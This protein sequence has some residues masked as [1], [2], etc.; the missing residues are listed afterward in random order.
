MY[1]L[2]N[3][4]MIKV[5]IVDDSSFMRVKIRSFLETCPDIKIV[6]IARNGLD[7]VEKTHIL[8][9]DVIT[10]DINMPGLS[11]IQAVERIMRECPTRILIVSSLAYEGAAETLEALEKGAVDYIHKDTMTEKI[12]V[13]KIRMAM[14]AVITPL[15]PCTDNV[16]T[17]AEDTRPSIK[18]ILEREMQSLDHVVPQNPFRLVAIGISTGGP[19]ALASIIPQISPD[20]RASIVVGQHMPAAFT[21]PLAERLDKESRIRVKEAED[22]EPL[23]PGCVYICPGGMHVMFQ[24]KDIISLYPKENFHEYHYCPSADL[25]MASASLTYGRSALLII[26]TGMGSDGMEG[27]KAA[28]IQG[29]YVLAQSEET[30]TIYGMPKAVISNNLQN[31]IVHLGQIAE[32]INQ[33]CSEG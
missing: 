7:A 16:F 3:L 13:D 26:M 1:V 29:S 22:G 32:R 4:A 6:G 12:L 17:A 33:L 28:R 19:K 18:K 9:P 20:I 15:P 21:R 8:M 5:L 14:D 30:S 23:L 27:I 25:L 11:G 31:E 2:E 10:M 24:K